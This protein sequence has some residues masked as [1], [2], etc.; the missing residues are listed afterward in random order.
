M[1]S[2]RRSAD[3]RGIGDHDEGIRRAEQSMKGAI[4]AIHGSAAIKGGPDTSMAQLSFAVRA[5]W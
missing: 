1:V 2:G 3:S 5:V 4:S